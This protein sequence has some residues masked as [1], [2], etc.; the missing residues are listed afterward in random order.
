VPAVRGAHIA[1]LSCSHWGGTCRYVALLTDVKLCDHITR[2]QKYR[3]AYLAPG[4][5]P[6]ALQHGEVTQ[7]PELPGGTSALFQVGWRCPAGHDYSTYERYMY[8]ANAFNRPARLLT[9]GT[10]ANDRGFDKRLC[11]ECI[12]RSQQELLQKARADMERNEERC[13]ESGSRRHEW[14]GAAHGDD[15]YAPTR[16]RSAESK[17]SLGSAEDE[18]RRLLAL[19]PRAPPAEVLRL[20]SRVGAEEVR[21]QFRALAKML[22]PDKCGLPR[23]S[24]AMQIVSEAVQ[25]LERQL[26]VL[27]ARATSC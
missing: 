20:P 16:A 8:L 1:T 12:R 19:P 9:Q 14:G 4:V 27:P 5:D 24:E 2:S 15:P 10:S 13:E 21:R 3:T 18:C 6:P 11:L 26:G 25:A 7:V 22:H 17:A 23:A